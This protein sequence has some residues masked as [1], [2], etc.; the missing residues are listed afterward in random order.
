M[1]VFRESLGSQL[2]VSIARLPWLLS[3]RVLVVV[4]AAVMFLLYLDRGR[5]G[6]KDVDR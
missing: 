4:A 1:F 3:D 6:D 5:H 2:S